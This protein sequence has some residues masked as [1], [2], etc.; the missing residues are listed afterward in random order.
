MIDQD[1][2]R[3]IIDTAE[4]VDVIQDFISLRKSGTNF[5]GLCPFHNEKSPS[6]FVSQSKGI[7]KCFGCGKGGS[8]VNFVME[9][10]N[11]TYPEALRYLAEKY[12]IEI[13][14]KELSAEELQQRNE[15]E[16]M[17]IVNVYAQKYFT[18]ILHSNEEGV[19]VGLSYLKERG[20]RTD[21]IRKFQLGYCING[22]DEFTQ[23]ALKNGYRLEYLLKCGLT[24]EK[25]DVHYDKFWGRVIFPVF[26]LAGKI[27]AFGGRALR[28]SEKA[29][30]YLNSPE[31]LIYHK[32]D[33]LYGIFFAKQAIVKQDRCY[34]VEG[35]TDV[36][37]MH[38]AGIEN[39]V[40]SSGTSLTV[41]QI[42]LIRRFT[43]NITIIYDGDEAGIKASLR[44]IDMVLEEGMNLKV[45][46]L[47][48]GDDPDSFARKADADQFLN[49]IQ[50]NEED[51][52][53][54]KTRLLLKDA[55]ND[56]IKRASLISDIVRS[57]AIIPDEII[58]TVYARECS[59]L[60]S[61]NE[62]V[63]YS[64][65]GKLRMKKAET[66]AGKNQTYNTTQS[67]AGNYQTTANNQSQISHSTVLSEPQERE[68]IR[69]LLNYG[70]EV[71]EI[72]TASSDDLTAD[73]PK[74]SLQVA[75]F[76]VNEIRNDELDFIHPIYRAIFD[77]YA[78][79]ID[80][81]DH[82]VTILTD[83]HFINHTDSK[84]SHIAA[85][86]LSTP[87]KLSNI[88]RRNDNYIQFEEINLTKGVPRAVLDF[89]DKKVRELLA[90]IIK[91]LE[92]KSKSQ[93]EQTSMIEKYML[94]KEISTIFAR[95]LG[96]RTIV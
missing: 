23:T 90:T 62:S 30:K 7:Y 77:E 16:S 88:W 73:T 54:F 53:N 8:A 55:A 61:V 17:L 66:D 50:T 19:N 83:K 24:G 92:D 81:L 38:Q 46:L 59:K 91:E 33:S 28:K 56:P 26:N 65:I 82:E 2:V 74:L 36:I 96:E 12:R 78:H 5:I 3:R 58:R 44:G 13:L 14:E 22:R 18:N 84:I 27:I 11:F 4:V 39:V 95:Q 51:F 32:S 52:I 9:H 57:I 40:A 1:T 15:R 41:N 10:E 70:S 76:V 42:R 6:F 43:N 25:N 45:V 35:Y 93:E 29:P 79:S 48:D 64:E 63:I 87:Y 94:L 37:S 21:I 85:D 31:S 49:F 71:I 67:Q 72:E 80:N 86:L 68:I 75:Q 89:K 34:L 20:F 69:L 60:L 47:P